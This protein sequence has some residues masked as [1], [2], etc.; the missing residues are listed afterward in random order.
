MITEDTEMRFK[1]LIH[2]F[3]LAVG[4]GMQGGGF[5]GVDLENGRRGRPEMGRE[6]R[7]R[8]TMKTDNVENE[9]AGEL[10]SSGK[11]GARNEVDH[12][13]HPIDEYED[14]ILAV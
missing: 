9:E 14:R 2:S 10:G 3:C 8:K 1:G 6:N 13:A 4:L 11:V 5:T 7:M 12:L